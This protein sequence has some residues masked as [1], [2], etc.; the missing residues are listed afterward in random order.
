MGG[1]W[2]GGWGGCGGGSGEVGVVRGGDQDRIHVT[3]L[4]YMIHH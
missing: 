4:S 1:G 3:H 2:L